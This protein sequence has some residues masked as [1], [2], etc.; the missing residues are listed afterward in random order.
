MAVLRKEFRLTTDVLN[1]LSSLA[2]GDEAQKQRESLERICDKSP[3]KGA[4]REINR[5][6]ASIIAQAGIPGLEKPPRDLLELFDAIARLLPDEAVESQLQQIAQE[7]DPRPVIEQALREL[8]IG[9][10]LRIGRDPDKNDIILVNDLTV[11]REHCMITRQEDGS[12]A[13][14]DKESMNG[15]FVWQDRVTNDPRPLEARDIVKLGGSI[16]E[17]T[18]PGIKS[19]ST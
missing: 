2:S 3:D 18:V 17:F 14:R 4:W 19:E 15:T 16:L 10:E 1:I 9:E 12:L 11:S 13:I 7:N 5:T 8:K 6:Q